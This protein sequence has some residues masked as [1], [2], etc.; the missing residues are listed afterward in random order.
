LVNDDDSDS[1]SDV[2]V[3][4]LKSQST[5]ASFSLQRLLSLLSCH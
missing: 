4:I 3:V 1:E 2:P 5:W